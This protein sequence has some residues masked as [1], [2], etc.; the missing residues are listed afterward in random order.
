[1]AKKSPLDVILGDV[2]K[3]TSTAKSTLGKTSS[4]AVSTWGS[5]G[6]SIPNVAQGAARKY[7]YVVN[8]AAMSYTESV[9]RRSRKS[10]AREATQRSYTPPKKSFPKISRAT[11]TP[12]AQPGVEAARRRGAV[13][14]SVTSARTAGKTA[15]PAKSLPKQMQSYGAPRPTSKPRS[16]GKGGKAASTGGGQVPGRRPGTS[17]RT[18]LVQ[19]RLALAAEEAAKGNTAAAAAYANAAVNIQKKGKGSAAS[20]KKVQKAAAAYAKAAKK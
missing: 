4:T 19:K 10:A 16:S 3:I 5:I 14:G 13:S 15:G 11:Q 17:A 8:P 18:A 7:A 9:L 2:R 20:M 6:R 12:S 1:M